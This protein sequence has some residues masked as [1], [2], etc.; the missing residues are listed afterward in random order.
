MLKSILYD[1]SDAYILLNGN[2]RAVGQRANAGAI[3][4]DINDKQVIFKN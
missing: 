3:A 2:I 4:D 1:Y